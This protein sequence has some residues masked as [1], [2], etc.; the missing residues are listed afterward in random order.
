MLVVRE[1]MAS[2]PRQV[3]VPFVADQPVHLDVTNVGQIPVIPSL[4]AM[5]KGSVRVAPGATAVIIIG[6]R[7]YHDKEPIQSAT[8]PFK[9]MLLP[10]RRL[11][12]NDHLKNVSYGV[13]FQRGEAVQ[14]CEHAL[15]TP[16]RPGAGCSKRG[17]LPHLQCG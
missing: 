12:R 2:P 6:Q 13:D 10:A 1:S 11:S 9:R 14:E 16:F 3:T 15:S 7:E 8:V 4:Y 17:T 5:G